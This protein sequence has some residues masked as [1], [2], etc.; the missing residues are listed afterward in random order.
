MMRKR[1]MAGCAS[2][3]AAG[4]VL[5]AQ[6]DEFARWNSTGVPVPT[7]GNFEP[8]ATHPNMAASNLVASANL[9]LTGSG[10]SS[11]TFA[12]GG[13]SATSSNEAKSLG[14]YWQTILQPQTGY[15]ASYETIR[16]R[17]RRSGSGPRWSQWSYS[18]NGSTF[19]WVPTVTS[20]SD[21][22]TEREIVLP[23]DPALQSTDRKIWFRMHA[24]GGTNN[25]MAW[26]AYGRAQDV[27]IFSGTLVATGPVPPT[28]VFDPPGAQSVSVSNTID[29]TISIATPD[30]GISGWLLS[31]TNHAG[32][33]GMVA[34]NF[35][36]TPYEADTSNTYVLSVVA[37]NAYGTSTGTT[38]ITVSGYVS[39]PPPGSYI[40]TFEDGSK[41][42]YASG[43]VT[44]SNKLWNLTDVLIGTIS[45][46]LKIGRK[47]ARLQYYT[48]DG[49][50]TMTVQTPVMSNGV[51][52][53][54]MWYGPYG[55]NGASAPTLAIEISE[56]L[57]EGWTE[58]G[59]AW[60]GG[61]SNLTFYSADVYVG[62]PVY[63][64]IRGKSGGFKR[65]ANFDNLTITPFFP[66]EVSAYDAYLLQYNV[67]PGDPGTEPEA[68]LDGDTA[69][70][71]N[72]FDAGTNPYDEASFP[73]P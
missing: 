47:A 34:T 18:T 33:A 49:P 4:C 35:T 39:P 11:D 71:T 57:S 31:P 14:H 2:V 53:I 69:S 44:L 13:Y 59:S 63:V 8:V 24:W 41:G 55:T 46:D 58:V 20:N 50:D 17:F 9:D 61:V 36:F 38:S 7:A 5:S 72:E 15:I 37:T 45:S 25:S 29:M 54:S 21:S 64:R 6:A 66:R 73:P 51:G 19:F 1:L 42:E 65:T 52:T 40:C 70:N 10:A 60:A 23:V 30:S 26:G 56:S 16:Y 43:N 62:T 22:Y 48:N 32:P 68:D 67:T 28:V 12:A 3:L 27:L